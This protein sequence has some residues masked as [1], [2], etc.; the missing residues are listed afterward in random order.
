M[1]KPAIITFLFMLFLPTFSFASIITIGSVTFERGEDN[2]ADAAVRISG[3]GGEFGVA[4]ETGL[5]DLDFE[6]GCFNL[7][8]D[9]VF[10]LDFDVAFSNQSGD[11]LYFTDTRFSAD[12]LAFSMDGVNFFNIAAGAFSDTGIDGVLNGTF[13]FDLFAVTVDLSNYGFSSGGMFNSIWIRGIVESDPTLIAN[14]NK[15][16]VNN[17]PA[18]SALSLLLLSFM[19]LGFSR[20]TRF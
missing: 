2:F 10:R 13:N 8:N 1:K 12:A 6:T 7:A 3:S 15:T 14:L 9:D 11:D 19:V 4:C 18:P 16:L 5:S 17:V 20:K